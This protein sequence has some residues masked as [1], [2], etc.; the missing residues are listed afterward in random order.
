MKKVIFIFLVLASFLSNAKVVYVSARSNATTPNGQSWATAYST[1]KQGLES[2]LVGDEVW[3]TADLYWSRLGG[4]NEITEKITLTR[5]IKVYGGFQGVETSLSQRPAATRTVISGAFPTGSA[6]STNLI[7]VTKNVQVLFDRVDFTEIN[8][9]K[10]DNDKGGAILVDSS[11]TVQFERC[12][13]YRCTASFRTACV[14]AQAMSNLRFDSCSFYNNDDAY[15]LIFPYDN[16]KV[17]MKNCQVYNNGANA[18]VYYFCINGFKDFDRLYPTDT[19][20]IAENVR[21]VGNGEMNF[22]QRGKGSTAFRNCHFEMSKG[23]AIYTGGDTSNF[24]YVSDCF[25]SGAPANYVIYNWKNRIEIRNCIFDGENQVNSP[26][27]INHSDGDFSMHNTR[28]MRH[29]N[30]MFYTYTSD[31]TDKMLLEGCTFSD[32]VYQ[33]FNSNFSTLTMRNCSF[34]NIDMSNTSGNI[35]NYYGNKLLMKGCSFTDNKVA[36]NISLF[37]KYGVD[38]TFL[39]SCSFVHNQ[40]QNWPLITNGE[41]EYLETTRSKYIANFSTYNY[42]PTGMIFSSYSGGFR[43]VGNLYYQNGGVGQGSSGVANMECRATFLNDI[44]DGNKGDSSGAISSTQSLQVANCNFLNSGNNAIRN[45]SS[46]GSEARARVYNSIFWNNKGN[47]INANGNISFANCFV[48]GTLPGSGHQISPTNPLSSNYE[49]MSSLLIDKGAILPDSLRMPAKDFTGRN[50]IVNKI[51]IGAIEGT[52]TT[53]LYND[54]LP[55]T[56]SMY[57]NPAAQGILHLKTMEKGHLLIQ[58]L[59]GSVAINI[60]VNGSEAIDVSAL[61]TGLYMVL[62]ETEKGKQTAKLQIK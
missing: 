37:S 47:Y 48:D 44:F 15:C 52:I 54:A 6:L 11:S 26:G 35:F 53:D 40:T 46:Y 60:Q 31:P 30:Y 39:D 56:I 17:K 38:S 41:G 51:D 19:M 20:V 5:S 3:I 36:S 13:F 14:N 1:I 58:D 18:R 62:L 4:S 27:F 10:T 55:S 7:R 9:A 57:P 8:S 45:Y 32:A 43:S 33:T 16:A 50:R 23:N 59:T 49:P 22:V 24:T 28:F 29:R 34:S 61:A 42:M 21:V 12:H 25:F 2:A